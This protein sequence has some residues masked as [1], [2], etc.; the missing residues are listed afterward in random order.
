MPTAWTKTSSPPSASSTSVTPARQASGSRRSACAVASARSP[1]AA[2]PSALT[3]STPTRA[4]AAAKPSATAPPSP[5]APATSTR[6]PVRPRKSSGIRRALAQRQDVQGDGAQGRDR[7]RVRRAARGRRELAGDH[8][9]RAAGDDEVDL[10]LEDRGDL[11]LR[12][13]VLLPARAR[14]VAVEDR[15]ELRRVDGRAEDPGTRL[16]ELLPVPVDELRVG[17]GTTIAYSLAFRLQ[18]VWMAHIAPTR[19][20]P[21]AGT[22]G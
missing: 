8:V 9:H 2:R 1:S 6:R 14:A 20:A 22:G 21:V 10:A 13:L 4:P 19:P 5:P 17:H 3:S 12:V 15:G 7:R 11:V 16:G 18:F